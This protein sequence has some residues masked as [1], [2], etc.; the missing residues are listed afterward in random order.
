LFRSTACLRNYNCL[1]IPDERLFGFLNMQGM[2]LML[3]Y[4]LGFEWQFSA[5]IL[6]KILKNKGKTYF[7]VEMPIINCRFSRTS[8][9]MLSKKTK[10]FIFVRVKLFSLYR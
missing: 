5:Y 2:T 8:A 7:V 10:A 9:S 1:V 3:L 6:N 4:L